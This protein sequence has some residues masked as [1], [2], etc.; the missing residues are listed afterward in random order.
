MQI[1]AKLSTVTG[2]SSEGLTTTELPAATAGAIFL[3]AMSCGMASGGARVSLPARG[4]P[5]AHCRAPARCAH[6]APAGG[7][8]A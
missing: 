5:C 3:I 6:H 7:S 1:L 4:G 2:A 8:T